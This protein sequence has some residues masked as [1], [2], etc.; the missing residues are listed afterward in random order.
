MDTK[1]V[2]KAVI[3]VIGSAFCYYAH[4]N[5]NKQHYDLCMYIF[6]VGILALLFNE[7]KD[8][9]VLNAISFFV[10]VS[11]CYATTKALLEIGDKY[12]WEDWLVGGLSLITLFSYLIYLVKRA[13]K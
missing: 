4:A 12:I 7:W 1:N 9:K 10:L 8:K 2:H 13:A 11:A 3:F 5:P 6:D